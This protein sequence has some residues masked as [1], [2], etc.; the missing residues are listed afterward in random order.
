MEGL[1][2]H[3]LKG[4]TRAAP[5]RCSHCPRACSRGHRVCISTREH[6]S[7]NRRPGLGPGQEA[8]D[9]DMQSCP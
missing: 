6:V 5:D 3:P 7:T 4:E 2:I 1:Q 9:T 8:R